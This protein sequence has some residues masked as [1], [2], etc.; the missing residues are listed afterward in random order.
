V[1]SRLVTSWSVTEC[2]II[3]LSFIYGTWG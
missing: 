2:L 3:V 1:R